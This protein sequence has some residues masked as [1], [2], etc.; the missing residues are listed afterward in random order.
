MAAGRRCIS[1]S[2]TRCIVLFL[3]PSSSCDLENPQSPSPPSPT[4]PPRF[5]SYPFIWQIWLKH[6]LYAI[7]GL[8]VYWG[9]WHWKSNVGTAEGCIYFE[10]NFIWVGVGD[11]QRY[12][13]FPN[14]SGF[15]Q[16]LLSLHQW[17]PGTSS[18]SSLP[19]I[20]TECLPH[21]CHPAI[22][23]RMSS[24]SLGCPIN[25][26]PGKCSTIQ[27]NKSLRKELTVVYPTPSVINK[28]FK[29]QVWSVS[30][31]TPY[32]AIWNRNVQMSVTEQVSK[33]W[34]R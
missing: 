6:P 16:A 14:S 17:I 11:I 27:I 21:P 24:R 19:S 29:I 4:F 2:Y 5:R 28:L 22:S 34:I 8:S 1:N 25:Q 10:S 15:P 26:V 13:S 9:R 3:W 23:L 18:I 20:S 31:V 12:T 30:Q 7:I 33:C 32:F